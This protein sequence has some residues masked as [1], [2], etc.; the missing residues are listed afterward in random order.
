MSK[1]GDQLLQRNS[2]QL[3]QLRPLP[4]VFFA[5]HVGVHTELDHGPR[6]REDIAPDIHDIAAASLFRK[7]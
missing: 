3:S 6:R 1:N 2:D 5:Q 4:P 7:N